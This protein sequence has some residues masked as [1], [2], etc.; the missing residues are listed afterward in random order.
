MILF[1]AISE[2]NTYQHKYYTLIILMLYIINLNITN[3]V[4]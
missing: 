3:I 2:N 4:L 1:R